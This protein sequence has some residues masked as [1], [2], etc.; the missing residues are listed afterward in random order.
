MVSEIVAGEFASCIARQGRRRQAG[1]L[2]PRDRAAERRRRVVRL[3][4]SGFF[5]SLDCHAYNQRLYF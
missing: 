4:R 1:R 3:R 5:L 2:W